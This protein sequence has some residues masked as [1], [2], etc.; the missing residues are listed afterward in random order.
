[1]R[2]SALTAG[3]ALLAA[4]LAAVTSGKEQQNGRQYR[5]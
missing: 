1:L 4:E 3:L 2:C 5:P